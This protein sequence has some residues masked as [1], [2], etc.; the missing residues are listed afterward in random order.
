MFLERRFNI[1]ASSC[2]A[3]AKRVADDCLA[4][5]NILNTLA[6]RVGMSI[7]QLLSLYLVKVDLDS[8]IAQ[9]SVLM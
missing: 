3:Y 8:S 5:R 9:L 2:N 6:Q 4:L 7:Q 1:V